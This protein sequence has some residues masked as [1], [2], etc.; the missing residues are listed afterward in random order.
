MQLCRLRPVLLPP[1]A[2]EENF[3]SVCG[4]VDGSDSE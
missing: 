4:D 2:D 3:C 1:V